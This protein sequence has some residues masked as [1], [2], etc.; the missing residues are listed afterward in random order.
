MI[1]TIRPMKTQ[2][3]NWGVCLMSILR[4]ADPG[5]VVADDVEGGVVH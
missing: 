4:S 1:S 2:S 3:D 5:Q